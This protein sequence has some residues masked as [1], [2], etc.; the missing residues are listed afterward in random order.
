MNRLIVILVMCLFAATASAINL[1]FLK[2]SVLT[3]FTP[4]EMTEFRALVSESMASAKDGTV[5]EWRSGSGKITA[6][7]LFRATY[8]NNASTT[9]R[10]VLFKIGEGD[11]PPERYRF[12]FCDNEGQWQY[13]QTSVSSF[14][15]EDWSYL[16]GIAIDTLDNETDGSPVSWVFRKTGNSGVVIPLSTTEINGLTCRETAFSII[17]RSGQTF[18]GKYMLCK[19]ESGEW[20]LIDR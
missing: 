14:T 7:V 19:Q 17:N 9:C 5:V 13:S 8:I 6:R 2:D 20:Q 18:D 4:A 15:T 11:R 12:D 10:R 3:R 16:N 1:R